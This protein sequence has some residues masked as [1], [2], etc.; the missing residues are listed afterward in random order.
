MAA[1]LGPV[2]SVRVVGGQEVSEAHPALPAEALGLTREASSL[3]M[4]GGGW[5][6]AAQ[7]T[8]QELLFFGN[9]MVVIFCHL[10]GPLPLCEEGRR[11]VG[12]SGPGTGAQQA[13]L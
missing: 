12:I 13:R 2:S 10:L 5:Q 1:S 9:P 6:R 11:L 3:R 7:T 8:C 4:A